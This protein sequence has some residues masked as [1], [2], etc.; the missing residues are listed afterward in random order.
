MNIRYGRGAFV[1][2]GAAS[3]SASASLTA[4]GGAEETVGLYGRWQ[5]EPIDPPSV[6]SGKVPRNRFGNYDLLHPLCLP[7]GAAHLRMPRVAKAAKS[8]GVSFAPAVVAF[9]FKGGVMAPRVDGVIVAKECEGLVRDAWAT[10]EQKRE[11]E[12]ARA[13]AKRV[14][15]RWRALV[16]GALLSA[17]VSMLYKTVK[18][19][20]GLPAGTAAASPAPATA[21]DAGVGSRRAEAS[22]GSDGMGSA[23]MVAA[24]LQRQQ[25][26]LA[27]AQRAR[28][29]EAE[30]LNEEQ[31]IVAR[32]TPPPVP[33][34]NVKERAGM[35]AAVE[36]AEGSAQLLD[37]GTLGQTPGTAIAE[38]PQKRPR[39]VPAVSPAATDATS[40]DDAGIGAPASEPHS[41][42][43]AASSLMHQHGLEAY[44]DT[45]QLDGTGAAAPSD[46]FEF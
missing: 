19:R 26:V 25:A 9:E 22:R 2:V 45:S 5:T 6:V 42:R 33:A 41:K 10:L 46:T 30:R 44:P 12:L 11:E 43:A 18:S 17:R 34:A 4:G 38:Q 13:R 32:S 31:G 23:G 15:A 36:F 14:T 37:P 20:S 39:P 29:A 35:E 40:R 21:P 27:A 8:V 28:V 7:R 24:S 3:A 1:P 16:T